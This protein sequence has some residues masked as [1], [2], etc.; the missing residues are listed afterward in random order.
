[1]TQWLERLR[2][3]RVLDLGANTG[4]Y[5]LIAERL[6]ALVVALDADPACIEA[7]YARVREDKLQGLLPLIGDLNNPSPRI[8]WANEE[9]LHLEER[10]HADVVLALALVHH[11]AIG[12]NVP[13]PAFAHYLA[14]LG[15]QAIVEFVP[16]LDPMVRRMLSARDDVF[17]SY[18]IES[19]E[20]AFAE[21]FRIADRVELGASGRVL[22]LMTVR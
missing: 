19:F 7:I 3:P 21:R 11:V 1:M 9:R 12:N 6:G 13:L 4:R 2:P 20:R 18:T 17:G 10:M 22:Y 15:R 14:R 8:G 16:K 5:S